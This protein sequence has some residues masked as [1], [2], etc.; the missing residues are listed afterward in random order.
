MAD[1]DKKQMLDSLMAIIIKNLKEE[2]RIKHLSKNLINTIQIESY[3]DEIKIHIP[4]KTYN[5]LMY[6]TKGV[7]I[8][9]S[10]GSYAS[11]LDE[12]GS[13]FFLYPNGTR[14]GSYKI[15][16]HNHKGYIERVIN[17]S[18]QE[19]KNTLTKAQYVR[20]ERL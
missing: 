17:K 10:N 2:F 18:I 16:P 19:W 8:H 20:G 3:S 7:V 15:K 9:T 14:K 13:E 11:K 1:S 4:A 5:M 12:V 6:Q